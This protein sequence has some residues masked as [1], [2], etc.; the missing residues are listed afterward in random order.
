MREESLKNKTILKYFSVLL[1]LLMT[2]Q[3][4]AAQGG[5]GKARLAGSVLDEERNPIPSAKIVIDLMGIE[6]ATRETITDNEG[7]WGFIGLGS[8]TW[9]LTASAEGFYPMERNINVSQIARN[10]KVVLNL[11]KM[12]KE[13]FEETDLSSIDQASTLFEERKYSEALALLQEFLVNNPTAYPTHINIGDCYK[14]M[15]EYDKAEVE[16]NL[17]LEA[18]KTDEKLGKEITAKAMANIG[19]IYMKKGDFESAQ[20]YFTQSIELL[21]DNEI[22]AYNVGEIYFSNRELNDAIRYY[23]TAIQ[24]KPDWGLPYHKLGLVYLNLTDYDKAKESFEKFL[25]VDPE[26]ELAESVRSMLA[27]IE[28]IK[29]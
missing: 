2:V 26:S 27:T 14:E 5:R 25:Q 12:E 28:Q 24:I 17:A 6:P 4:A 22:L 18:A 15:Q 19:D 9:Q 20:N 7:D 16:Y 1:F 21:P 3:F 8:G 11:K 13:T 10:P 29:K 23:D